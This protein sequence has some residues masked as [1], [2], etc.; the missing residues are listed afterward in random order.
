[1]ANDRFR[2][3]IMSRIMSQLLDQRQLNQR[4]LGML[5]P[6]G[7]PG[8]SGGPGFLPT[9]QSRGTTDMTNTGP[10]QAMNPTRGKVPTAKTKGGVGSQ[11]VQTTKGGLFDKFTKSQDMTRVG[12]M[13][14]HV[15]A[16]GGDV[17]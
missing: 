17:G 12:A 5:S 10:T 6:G 3:A 8:F 14:R 2:S 1:M 16:A 4:A 11:Q 15:A 13:K 7:G 9:P